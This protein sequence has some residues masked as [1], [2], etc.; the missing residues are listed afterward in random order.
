MNCGTSLKTQTSVDTNSLEPVQSPLF[1]YI[2]KEL[3]A[4]LITARTSGGMV[5]ERRVVTMLFCDLKGSTAA[6]EQLDPEDWAEI[7]NGAFEKLIGP[8]YRYEGTLARLMGD[9]ILAF[10]GAPITHEDDPQRAVLAG[11]EI[12]HGIQPYCEQVK[13]RWNLEINVRV[14]IN[15]GLV[16]VGEV[17]SDLRMEYTAL[18]DAINLAARMEQTAQPGTIQVTEQTYRLVAPLFDFE[19]LGEVEVKGKRQP[20]S[21][22]R[23]LRE[24]PSPGRLRGITG[25]E[26]P[27]IGRDREMDSLQKRINDLSMGM[28]SIICLVGEAGLGKTRLVSEF[29]KTWLDQT[30]QEQTTT[31]TQQAPHAPTGVEEV[32]SRWVESQALSYES[33]RPYAQIQQLLR[34]ASGISHHDTSADIEIKLNALLAALPDEQR[35]QAVQIF[36]ILLGSAHSGKQLPL[37]GEAFQRQ[38]FGLMPAVIRTLVAGKPFILVFD[39]LHWADPASIKLIQHLFPLTAQEPLI[40]LCVFRP[41]RQAPVWD[42]MTTAERDFGHRYTEIQL[43]PLSEQDSNTLIDSLLTISDLPPQVR[44]RI[45]QHAEGNPF[46]VE[47]IVRTLIERGLVRQDETGKHWS[48]AKDIE[49]TNI[50]LPHNLRGLLMAR[51]DSLEETDK[52]LLQIAAV[53]GRRFNTQILKSLVLNGNG[54]QSK[55]GSDSTNRSNLEQTLEN[56]QRAQLIYEIMRLP[57]HE[58]AFRHA[59]IQEAAYDTILLKKRR[60]FHLQIG[61]AIEKRY[62]QQLEDYAAILAHHFSE[63]NDQRSLKYSLTAGN[64]AFRLY[65]NAE[66]ISHYTRALETIE[67]NDIEIKDTQLTHL[68]THRGRAY[69]L[70]SQFELALTNY[71]QMERTA[72]QRG[73][74]PMELAALV[75]QA[76]IRCTANDL[77]DPDKGELLCQRSLS[78]AQQVGDPLAEA[79]TYWNQM[80]LYRLTDQNLHALQAGEDALTILRGLPTEEAQRVEVR[81]QLAYT[82]NDFYHVSSATQS[83]ELALDYL[84]EAR[85]LWTELEN[86]PMLADNL[87]TAALGYFSLNELNKSL[88]FSEQAYQLSKSTNNLWG[89]SYSRYMVGLIYWERGDVEQAFQMMNE[90]ISLGQQAGFI[91]VQIMN[92]WFLAWIYAALG[93]FDK[94]FEIAGEIIG[95]LPQVETFSSLWQRYS[96]PLMAELFILKG[97]ISKAE[98]Q[99]SQGEDI[100]M[101]MNAIF[102]YFY[103][104]TKSRV[105][106]AR[107]NF[108]QALKLAQEMVSLIHTSGSLYYLED[109][110]F[111]GIVLIEMG[112]LEQGYETLMEARER[113]KTQGSKWTMWKILTALYQVERQRGDSSAAE[114]LLNEARENIIY[115]AD[116][117]GDEGLRTTF[118]A[119]PEVM[120]VLSHQIKTAA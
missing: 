48:A 30:K 71:E 44:E 24:K 60:V 43:K 41:Y 104:R 113:A 106:L 64:N 52:N 46:F 81:E 72:L 115:I 9:A 16:V 42:L 34:H 112:R 58:F 119:Q 1:K 118:L 84:E 87:A 47:E 10:F 19:H 98:E 35:Q 105:A 63:A 111:R 31:S 49:V 22:Y 103:L 54:S 97:E 108:D 25:L 99:L 59:L 33:T 66:A 38:L 102:A 95:Q 110:Y 37:E 11:L 29:Q 96:I 120:E 61:E 40:L 78:L 23:V 8:I 28:G 20:V 50:G 90:T 76:Q 88:S 116:H 45:S 101:E 62:P 93:A 79:K 94:G 12:L 75:S 17:G 70:N 73:D 53:I 74:R 14:G 85:A 27:M 100:D 32:A 13:H 6:A 68:Y 51:I 77:F 107:K 92:R 26:A 82:L 2:P 83:V 7:M 117:I 39:D 5:G 57:E 15:T 21:A 36:N 4:K 114:K 80:N 91:I 3:L 55:Q 67:A 56:L 109:L 69:E 65:A 89:M 18:G 86:Q